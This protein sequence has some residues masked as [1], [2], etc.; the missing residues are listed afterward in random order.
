MI[1]VIYKL[2]DYF[3][4]D[5]YLSMDYLSMHHAHSTP[6]STSESILDEDMMPIIVNVQSVDLPIHEKPVSYIQPSYI[7]YGPISVRKYHKIA[8]T[9]ATGRRPNGVIIQGEGGDVIKR[10]IRQKKNRESTRN[11]KKIRDDVMKNLE[12]QLTQ[13]QSDEHQLLTRIHDLQIYKTNLQV[14]QSLH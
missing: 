4:F 5:R 14:I 7:N 11:L 1:D 2:K 6:I 9:L 13:L 8:P 12:I 10:Q 3:F